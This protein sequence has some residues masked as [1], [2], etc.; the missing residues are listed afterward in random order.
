M[1]GLHFGAPERLVFNGNKADFW[2]L[3]FKKIV[4]L[5]TT[6]TTGPQT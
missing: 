6:D 3:F 4:Q 2:N 5:R 1:V